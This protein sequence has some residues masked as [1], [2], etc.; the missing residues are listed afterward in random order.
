MRRDWREDRIRP[1][2]RRALGEITMPP[3][4]PRRPQHPNKAPQPTLLDR[5][6]DADLGAADR[7]DA[8]PVAAP[9]IAP[10]S[11]E[12]DGFEAPKLPW[13]GCKVAGEWGQRHVRTHVRCQIVGV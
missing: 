7:S 9:S 1:L 5:A 13:H 11:A 12:P 4:T 2:R 6:F 3:G 10:D 8:A